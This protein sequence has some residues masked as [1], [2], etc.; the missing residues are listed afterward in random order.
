MIGIYYY[1]YMKPVK[2]KL[3]KGKITAWLVLDSAR[4]D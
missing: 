2:F 1:C 4:L 3:F